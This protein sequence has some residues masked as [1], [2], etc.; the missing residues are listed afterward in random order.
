MLSTFAASP[1]GACALPRSRPTRAQQ[2]VPHSARASNAAARP[3]GTE[4][5]RGRF[6]DDP[7]PAPSRHLPTERPAKPGRDPEAPGTG[8]L[9]PRGKA[10]CPSAR[11]T[12][13]ASNF[14]LSS[15]L[16]EPGFPL[17]LPLSNLPARSGVQPRPLLSPAP[18]QRLRR[19]PPPPTPAR[20]S[21]YLGSGLRRPP[22]GH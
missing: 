2:Y 8:G 1:S 21:T 12:S 20:V 16:P 6:K 9:C 18:R 13:V 10:T 4:S 5:G 11:P 3:E 22:V 15:F 19:S 14:P 17:T 7:S